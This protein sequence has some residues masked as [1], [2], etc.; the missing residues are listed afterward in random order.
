MQALGEPMDKS[1]TIMDRFGYT[2]SASMPM[3]L[4]DAVRAGRDRPC[5][6]IVFTCSGA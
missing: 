2:G 5:G 4:D 3:A 1:H 6:L